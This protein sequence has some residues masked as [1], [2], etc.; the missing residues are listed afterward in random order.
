MNHEEVNNSEVS[1][2]ADLALAITRVAKRAANEEE[3]R[4]GVEKLLE[5]TEVVPEIWTGC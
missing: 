1:E 3:L 5:P 4:I 2:A